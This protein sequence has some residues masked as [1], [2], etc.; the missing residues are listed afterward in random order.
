MPLTAFLLTL[1]FQM[2]ETQALAVLITGSCP[3]GTTSNA[4]ALWLKGDMDL[5]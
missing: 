4:A 3:G 2:D 5:R 1:I